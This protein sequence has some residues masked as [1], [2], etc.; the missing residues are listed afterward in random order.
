MPTPR[1]TRSGSSNIRLAKLS[2]VDAI[3]KLD[4]KVFGDIDGGYPDFFF[5]HMVSIFPSTFWVLD[6]VMAYCLVILGETSPW[7]YSIAVDPSLQGKNIG[8]R[9]I[10]IAERYLRHRNYPILSLYVDI[11]NTRGISLYSKL[12]FRILGKRS[13]TKPERLLMR[14]VL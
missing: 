12:H 5:G 11:T 2:D 9:M 8:S 14:K 7:L 3:T 10:D 1:K 13:E 6:D 4:K